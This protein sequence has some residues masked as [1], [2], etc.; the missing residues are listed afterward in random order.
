MTYQNP[1]ISIAGLDHGDP[2]VLKYNGNYF[3]YHTGP[4]EIRVYTST[5]LVNWEACGVALHAS[6]ED[7]HWAQVDLW[8]PEI[9]HENGTFYMYVT[10]AV[11]D[12]NGH[13]ND[14]IRRIGVAKSKSPTGPFT[15]A[16]EPLTDEWSIDAHPFKDEDGSYYMFYNVRNEYTRGP[17]N[18]IGTGNVVDRMRDLETLSGN[19][20]MVV[21]PEHLWE[22]NKEHS[23]F[24]NEGPFVL[25]KDGT[26]YQMYSA[27]F[28]GDDTYGVY[29][30]T[31]SK[32]MGDHGMED[33]SWSKW[34]GGEPILKT[35]DACH[36]PGHHVVVKGPNGV[37]DYIVY[38]GYEP[39]ENVG[40]RRVRVGRF[41]WQGDHIW[42]E[43]PVKGE[44]PLPSAPTY[45]GRFPSSISEVNAGLLAH[46]YPSFHFET[47]IF[48]PSNGEKLVYFLSFLQGDGN[49]VRWSF[50]R[51]KSIL[52]TIIQGES[53]SEQVEEEYPLPDGH[54]FSAYHFVQVKKRNSNLSLYLNQL[55]VCSIELEG[56]GDGTINFP[57]HDDEG[58][59]VEGTVL[60][61]LKEK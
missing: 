7:G 17:N 29:Y 45:D 37:D 21:A 57:F 13:G 55:L 24:W 36:G 35:N 48:L 47:N 23:F 30:A 43:P 11:R 22:G 26:Y 4:R 27:G 59:K 20:T 61:S 58:L 1:V 53:E 60:T 56:E 9:I 19:P 31:S 33:K 44:L 2:A 10:G 46:Q 54:D 49:E 39:E 8:A 38:H 25:K 16:K 32:P 12:E 18:V 52:K 42:L 51:E 28:F 3:L 41:Q 14:E 40:E 6:D 34:K 50:D 5:D 15:L